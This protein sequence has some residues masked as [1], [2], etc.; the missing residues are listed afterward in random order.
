VSDVKPHP[1]QG[2]RFRSRPQQACAAFL[3]S[4]L[5]SGVACSG[6][7]TGGEAA[8]DAAQRLVVMAPAAAEM[9]DVLGVADRVVGVGDFVP[10]FDAVPR[11]GAYDSPN[12]ERILDLG[13]DAFV[14]TASQAAAPAHARLE[15]LG[16]RVVALDTSTYEGMLDSLLALGRSVGREDE[17]RAVV[18]RVR[19]ELGAIEA[20]A[21]ERPRRGVLF[22][23]GRDPLYVAGPGSHV[24]EMIVRAGG[25]NVAHDTGAPYARMSIEAVL[26]RQPE[27]IVDTS[28]NRPGALRGRVAGAWGE[29]E[30][31]PAVRDGAV[32]QVDPSRLAIPGIRL[33][34]M[35]ERLGR[36]IH[37]EIFGHPSAQDYEAAR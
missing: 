18:E 21:A 22:V 30:F 3:A 31:L 13:A 7:V 25:V 14:T 35:T 2:E 8:G 34:E 24:D 20:R 11:V 16:V 26:E 32:H 15:A 29:W 10:G 37:P 19:R 33:P 28:D 6:A 5:G 17:A 36:M 1:P 27:V 23:V 9:L 12:A 4:L